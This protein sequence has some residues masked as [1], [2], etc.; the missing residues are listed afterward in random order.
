LTK[1]TKKLIYIWYMGWIFY[2]YSV[3]YNGNIVIMC[4]FKY[5]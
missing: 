3:K 4:I 2:I 1:S 5:T